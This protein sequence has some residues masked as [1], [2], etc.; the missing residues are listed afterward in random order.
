[1]RD[2][3][4]MRRASAASIIRACPS[5]FTVAVVTRRAAKLRSGLYLGPSGGA[6]GILGGLEG[7]CTVHL[8]W[9]LGEM[10]CPESRSGS[11]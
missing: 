2:E 3:A 6:I 7:A 10:A 5:S 1:V 4:R 8:G 9:V 11:L